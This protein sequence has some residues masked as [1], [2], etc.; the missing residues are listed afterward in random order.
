MKLLMIGD[1]TMQTNKKSTFPQFGWGQL[2]P[3]FCK[4][5]LQIINFGKNKLSTKTACELGIF[6]ELLKLVDNE[7]YVILQF[8]HN[9]RIKD[10]PER[11]VTLNE[12][13]LNLKKMIKEIQELGGKVILMTPTYR[14]I[15]DNDELRKD[16]LEE[17]P[18]IVEK[19]ARENE[20]IF[21]DCYKIMYEFF[22]KLTHNQS[23]RYVM[24]F[25]PGIYDN[26]PCGSKDDTHFRVD[27][28]FLISKI[29]SDEIKKKN[30]SLSKYF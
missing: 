14:L 28:A 5:S 2:L 29:F 15:Y 24:N 30:C 6:G 13:E 22:S 1:S 25:E 7:T 23:K 4:D 9:D 26:Y 3:M 8:G 21:I 20:V 27:G 18:G 19:V 12:F 11:Y 17:Y 16:V 10:K